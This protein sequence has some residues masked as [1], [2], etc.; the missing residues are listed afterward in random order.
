MGPRCD[1]ENCG[2]ECDTIVVVHICTACPSSTQPPTHPFHVWLSVKGKRE[3][4]EKGA[5]VLLMFGVGVYSFSDA[6]RFSTFF[7]LSF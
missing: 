4:R 5:S 7:F 1:E 3:E 2:S 6:S